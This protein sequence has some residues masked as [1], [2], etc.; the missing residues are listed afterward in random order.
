MSAPPAN[1]PPSVPPLGR[2]L[3]ELRGVGTE[4]ATQLARL[5]LFTIQGLVDCTARGVTK[6][7]V[8][9]APSRKC[10]SMSRARRAGK[11]WRWG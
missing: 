3:K 7:A 11:S 8:I 10:S 4:R 5:E 2:P 9:F 6:T 1:V